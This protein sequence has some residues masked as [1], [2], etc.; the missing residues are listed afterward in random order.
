[1]SLASAE[2]AKIKYFLNNEQIPFKSF[3]LKMSFPL[4]LSFAA[5]LN[6]ENFSMSHPKQ[7]LFDVSKCS[8]S[9]FFSRKDFTDEK[10]GSSFY[11]K[12]YLEKQYNNGSEQDRESELGKP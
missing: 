10:L 11:D 6:I 4:G 2:F 9:D 1:M 7:T 5:M 3:P 12:Y 8:F